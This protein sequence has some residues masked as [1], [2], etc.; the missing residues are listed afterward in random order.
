MQILTKFDRVVNDVS[1][2]LSYL[3]AFALFLMML[4]TTVDVIGRY[5]FRSPIP[6]GT[7]IT[8]AMMVVIAF[9]VLAWCAAKRKHVEVEILMS[10]F[11][12]KV[13][14][15]TSVITTFAI[16]AIYTL[17]TWQSFVYSENVTTVASLLRFPLYPFY[18]VLTAGFAV[19]CLVV[20]IQLIESIVKAVKG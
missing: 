6:G 13:Q 9:P 19:L 17:V 14:A 8:E 16:L 3:G 20:L 7:E 4:L 18:W 15:I 10:R 1:R 2:W 12:K 11:S 5:F